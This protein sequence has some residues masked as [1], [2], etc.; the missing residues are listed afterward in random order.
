M[1]VTTYTQEFTTSVAA[2][3]MFKA[4]MLDSHNLIPK[5]LPQSIKSI[6]YIQGD[7][8]AGS[9]KQTNFPEGSPMK[10][11][12]HKIDLL[13]VENYKCKYTVIEGD[14]LDDKL[15]SLSYEVKFEPTG[16]GCETKVTSISYYHAKGGIEL[17]EEEM[18]AGKDK[19]MGM[20]KV[21]EDYLIAN[22]DVYA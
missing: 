10:C 6:E 8:G 12:K 11:L 9:I 19:G 20:F 4:L 17:K 13:D 15:E 3:R 1:G 14:A 2:N 5:L 22:P 7:G 18:A 21:V 16:N